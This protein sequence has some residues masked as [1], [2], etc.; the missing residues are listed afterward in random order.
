MSV[1]VINLS[2]FCSCSPCDCYL[3][4]QWV[5][6]HSLLTTIVGIKCQW[7]NWNGNGNYFTTKITDTSTSQ[8]PGGGHTQPTHPHPPPV[9]VLSVP[10]QSSIPAALSL[11]TP[12]ADVDVATGHQHLRSAS[13][14]KLIVPRCR[15]DSYGRR[16]IAV[17][18]PSTWN[19]LPDSLRDPALSFSIFRRHLKTHFLQN[20]NREVLSALEI[21]LREG[22][23]QIWH[24][25]LIYLHVIASAD[26]TKSAGIDKK[27]SCRWQTARCSLKRCAVSL[28]QQELL[29]EVSVGVVLKE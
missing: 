1:F 4:I 8:H 27:F 12:T 26:E 20:I 7:F 11:S 22:T 15:M 6:I 21:F 10:T 17:E 13:Q 19:S 28:C 29:S 16:C 25:Y 18:G 9:V 14:R 5:W 3:S 23:S 2:I 24:F